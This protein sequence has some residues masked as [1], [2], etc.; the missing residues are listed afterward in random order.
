[1]SSK[2]YYT[3][4][5]ANRAIARI[6]PLVRDLSERA[7]V[8]RGLNP[9]GRDERPQVD[10]LVIPQYFRELLALSQDMKRLRAYGCVLK[11]LQSGIVDFPARLEGREVLLCWRLGEESISHWHELDAGFRGRQPIDADQRFEEGGSEA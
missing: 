8:L 5:E 11:D 10:S 7:E 6:E 2:R 9:G 1:M 4:G 3:P